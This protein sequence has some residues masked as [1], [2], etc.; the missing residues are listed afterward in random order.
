MEWSDLLDQYSTKYSKVRNLEYKA[1]LQTTMDNLQAEL[2]GLQFL[3]QQG[4]IMEPFQASIIKFEMESLT[5]EL[6]RLVTTKGEM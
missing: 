5:T 3:L 4:I 6:R 1:S 2:Q